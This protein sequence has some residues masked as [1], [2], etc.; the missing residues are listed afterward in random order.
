[1]TQNVTP[2]IH[3]QEDCDVLRMPK[4]SD[5]TQEFPVD[6]LSEIQD[7]KLCLASYRLANCLTEPWHK[8]QM[9]MKIL[10]PGPFKGLRLRTVYYRAVFHLLSF[11]ELF[12]PRDVET[13]SEVPRTV[14][15]TQ[16]LP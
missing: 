8:Q 5:G 3:Q 2:F 1:M 10:E 7:K 14:G 11:D 4:A 6:V 15:R 13:S 16:K 9:N 12:A